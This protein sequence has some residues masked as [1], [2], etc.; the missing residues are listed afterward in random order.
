MGYRKDDPESLGKIRGLCQQN[1]D[2]A[3]KRKEVKYIDFKLPNYTLE[4]KT[5]YNMQIGIFDTS[6]MGEK[7]LMK[8]FQNMLY[9]NNH[10]Y[11]EAAF[12]GED[13][14]MRYFSFFLNN[15]CLVIFLEDNAKSVE[16]KDVKK[17]KVY[18]QN[19]PI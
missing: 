11:N 14:K 6:K 4:I 18:T 19:F 15:L 5:N 16:I 8:F 7:K 9:F 1:Y 3:L 12:Y 10:V 2:Q 13:F 17:L